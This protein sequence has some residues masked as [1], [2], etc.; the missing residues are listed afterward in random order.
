MKEL[1]HAEFTRQVKEQL[2]AECTRLESTVRYINLRGVDTEVRI[3]ATISLG[4]LSEQ[5]SMTTHQCNVPIT[6]A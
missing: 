1:L 5:T 6:A 4:P 2:G 3:G